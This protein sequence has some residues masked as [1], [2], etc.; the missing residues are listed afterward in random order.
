[1][2]KI[3]WFTTG[4]D[5]EAFELLRDVFQA[6]RTGRIKGAISLCF[7]NREPGESFHSDRIIDFL[8]KEGIPYETLSTRRFLRERNLTLDSGREIFDE[9][10]KKIIQ[11]YS[12]D[13]IFLA[14]YMLIVSKILHEK[15]T[16]LNLHPSLPGKYKGK[17]EDVINSIIMNRDKEFGAMIHFAEEKLDEGKPITYFRLTVTDENILAL[18]DKAISGDEKSY[19]ELFQY[20]REKEFSLE[21]P[22]IIETL[23]LLSEGRLKIEGK[24]VYF[25]EVEISN[26]LDIT[27]LLKK[28]VDR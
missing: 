19:N 7:I 4:R 3:L 23:R 14:G 12:F 6:T 26:G 20:L 17:W 8:K 13:I 9:E 28:G 25:D 11:A 2:L 5:E 21:T 1:M 16:I 15:F 10:V 27:P 24:K 22:L 18:Y